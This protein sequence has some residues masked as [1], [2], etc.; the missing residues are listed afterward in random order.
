MGNY[1][2][3][4]RVSSKVPGGQAHPWPK[5]LAK[6]IRSSAENISFF[7]LSVLILADHYGSAEIMF[8][9]AARYILA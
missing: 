1:R 5:K 9:S 8:V 2:A 4:I 7:G 3:T 6:T